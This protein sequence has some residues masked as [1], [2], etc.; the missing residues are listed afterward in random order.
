M[1]GSPC[2]RLLVSES[3][4][5]HTGYGTLGGASVSPLSKLGLTITVPSS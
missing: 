3:Q 1:I 4:L 2:A 5:R